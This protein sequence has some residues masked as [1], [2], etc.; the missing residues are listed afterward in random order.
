MIASGDPG[1]SSIPDRFA[2]ASKAR[3]GLDSQ[4]FELTTGTTF[5]APTSVPGPPPDDARH[6]SP[7]RAGPPAGSPP[8]AGEPPPHDQL[9]VRGG[10][11]VKGKPSGI[12]PGDRLLLIA[13]IRGRGRTT[14]PRVVSVTGLVTRD[15]PARQAQHAGAADAAPA[16]LPGRRQGGRL[17]AQALDA[18]EPSRH[19][20]RRRRLDQGTARS[21]STATARFLHAGDPLLV[22]VPGAGTGSHHGTGFSVVQLTNYQEVLWYANGTAVDADDGTVR[23][24]D[25]ADVARARRSPSPPAAASARSASRDHRGRGPGSGWTDVG[26]L[27]DTP[28][29]QL[30]RRCRS[31]LTLARAP[32]APGRGRDAR[33]SSRTRTAT[34]PPS[35]RR[36][37]DGSSDVTIAAAGARRH[38]AALAPPLQLLWD[39]ITVT[40]GASVRG[41]QLGIGDATLAGQ[42]F[43]LSRSPV[44]YLADGTSGRRGA[45]ALRR[46]LLEHDRADRRRHPLD[47]GADAVRPAGP[48]R[49]CSRPTRTPPARRTS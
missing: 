1:P 45:V 31:K 14:P 11:L 6:R 8:G 37:T 24:P 44:T 19:G 4:T 41:E 7:R 9:I 21:C 3:P 17:R 49:S 40:R 46:R 16:A 27:L 5:T 42:D 22:E 30:S 28:V 32:A 18:H 47:R 20:S 33:R 2:I 39:L 10:V 38:D 15:R 34:A 23:Q 48:T 26:T 25:P 29:S 13:Q 43:T 36:P 35:P 12:K